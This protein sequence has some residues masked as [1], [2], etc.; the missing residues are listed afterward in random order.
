MVLFQHVI[1]G[2][3]HSTVIAPESPKERLFFVT[4]LIKCAN[5]NAA[6]TGT[7]FFIRVPIVNEADQL[8]LVTNRHIVRHPKLGVAD[9][10]EIITPAAD[11]SDTTRPLLGR[12]AQAT[13]LGAKFELHPNP[14]IDVAV[15]RV[16]NLAETGQ[17]TR[18][19][20]AI[21]AERLYN[22]A[23]VKRLDAIEQ[24]TFMGY[25]KGLY[26]TIN[27]LPVA[28]QGWT[29]TP[30]SIDFAGQPKFLVDASVFEG[31]SG[32]PVLAL[33]S[34]S[35]QERAGAVQNG[36]PYAVLLG[37]IAE[38]WAFPE[39]GTVQIGGAPFD[40]GVSQALNFGTVYKASTIIEAVGHL[41]SVQ[42]LAQ[43]SPN[44]A[45]QA[46]AV[47]PVDPP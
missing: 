19:V 30:I 16:D 39:T 22:E 42:G 25:P 17:W 8:I 45:A 20:K 44:P 27:M 40:F 38:T 29:A 5:N 10:I 14:N 24:V 34:G 13:T 1:L 33:N 3:A 41:L 36:S 28:R 21:P 35:Y 12:S 7:G 37:I 9:T 15:A 43:Q 4:A 26:D 31:S 6:W 2:K 11:P 32:S 46:T 47:W 23:L 18:Y